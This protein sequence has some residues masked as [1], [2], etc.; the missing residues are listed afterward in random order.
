MMID[1]MPHS[2]N[3]HGFVDRRQ[4]ASATIA[5]L[6]EILTVVRTINTS[7]TLS[8]V[9]KDLKEHN[10]TESYLQAGLR[11]NIEFSNRLNVA[12]TFV[13]I[14]VFEHKRGNEKG[15]VAAFANARKYLG[16]V[17][18]ERDPDSTERRSLAEAC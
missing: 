9:L 5:N 15:A 3:I 13:E 11:M 2:W 8:N 10:S 12:E 16:M 4:D 17:C 1:V 18:A 7:I 14:G 6:E